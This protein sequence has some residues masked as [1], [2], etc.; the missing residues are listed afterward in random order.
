MATRWSSPPERVS[1]SLSM[2]SSIMSGF[3]TSVWNWG[4]MYVARIFCARSWATEPLNLGE[5]FC[6][7]YET[8]SSGIS[9][10]ET[11]GLRSP[12]SMR[13]N[14]VFPVPFSPSMTMISELEKSPDSIE[15]R[16]WAPS[17]S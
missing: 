1:T 10:S 12:A 8:L 16:N 5:I 3:M 4:D 15:S 7:L 6:G 14:V 2:M 11:S 13:M 17:P 9:S